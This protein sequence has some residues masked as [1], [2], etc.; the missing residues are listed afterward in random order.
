MNPVPQ[1]VDYAQYYDHDH[2]DTVPDFEFYLDYARQCGSPVLELACGTGRLL[3]PLA[4]SGIEMTGVDLSENMLAVCKHKVEDRQ[5]AER[6]TL[7][8]ASM[9]DYDLPRKDF[10]LVFIAFRSFMHLY[11]Q[12]DQLACLRRTFE[13]L[14][15]GGTLIIDLYS[16]IYKFLAK[17]PDQPFSVRR[18]F[19]LPN[20]NHGI[21]K[22]RFVRNDPA[23]QIQHSELRIEEYDTEGALVHEHTVPISTRYTFRYEMQLLLEKVGF[24]VIEFFRDYDKNPFDGTGEIIV[25]ARRPHS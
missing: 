11:N 19:D 5:M 14:R 22:D 20:G 24:E 21:R 1:Y 7:V 18:E 3:I 23:L 6:V 15:S 13:H 4:E 12:Q 9:A 25:A 17:E 8:H 10:S 2:R 16:P